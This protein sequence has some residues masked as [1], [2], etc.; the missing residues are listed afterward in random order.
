MNNTEKKK[1]ELKI[2]R[3]DLSDDVIAGCVHIHDNI[4][5]A[6]LHFAKGLELARMRKEKGS[7]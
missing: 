1:E 6:K 7:E 2:A 4:K 5:L 3:P